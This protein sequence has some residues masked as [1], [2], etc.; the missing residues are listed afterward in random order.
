MEG[1]NW[2][3]MGY[4]SEMDVI[5]RFLEDCCEQ[6]SDSQTSSKDLYLAFEEWCGQNG[7]DLVTKN[8]F[9]RRL[10]E[11]GFQEVRTGPRR[12]RS[13]KGLALVSG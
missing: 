4:R 13:L 7:E 6:R 9:T 3:Q 8:L 12:I 1:C 10:K 2:H 5:A 11:M